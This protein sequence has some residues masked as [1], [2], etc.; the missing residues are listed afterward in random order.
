MVPYF[1]ADGE[2]F[3][4]VRD[5]VLGLLGEV[6]DERLVEE[7]LERGQAKQE[8]VLAFGGKTGAKHGVTS[9]GSET[10][11]ESSKPRKER[12]KESTCA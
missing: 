9:S 8:D 7:S 3:E 4:W 6:L 1:A 2:R 11:S 12:G 5:L 10:N